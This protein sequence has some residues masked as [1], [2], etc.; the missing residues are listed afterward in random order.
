MAREHTTKFAQV[1]KNKKPREEYRMAGIR[2]SNK[3]TIRAAMMLSCAALALSGAVAVAQETDEDTGTRTL[4]K[5]TVTARR[6]EENQQEV[7]VTV[8]TFSGAVLE[9]RGLTNITQIADFTPGL[10]IDFTSPISGSTASASTFIRGVGQSDFLLTIDPG[11]G[12]YVDGVYIA[13][14]VGGVVDLLSVD[15]VEV[16]KGPQGTLF[17]R[18]TIGGAINI[19]SREPGDEFAAQGEFTIGRFDRRDLRLSADVPLT[20]TLKLALAFSSKN[21]DGYAERIPFLG[22]QQGDIL[23]TGPTTDVF[24]ATGNPFLV[25]ADVNSSELGNE[26]TD[27]GRAA[28][29]WEP[30]DRLKVRVAADY[31]RSRESGTA[32]TLLATSAPIVTDALGNADPG[33]VVPQPFGPDSLG[34]LRNTLVAALFPDDI[35]QFDDR[36][37]TGDPDTTFATGPNFS[38]L[39]LFGVNFSAQYALTE[40]IDIEVIS[41]YRELEA[42]FGRDGDNSPLNIDHTSNLYNHQQFT[43]EIKLSGANFD[44]RL[45]WTGGFFYFQEEGDDNVFVPLGGVGGLGGA[46][47]IGQLLQLDELNQVENRSI[48]LFGEATAFLTDR[49]SFTGGLRWTDEQ[50]D[51]DPIHQDFGLFFTGTPFDIHGLNAAGTATL[52][53]PLGEVSQDFSNVSFRAGTEYRATDNLFLYANVSTGFKAG[54]FTGRTVQPV[55][56]PIPFDEETLI[57]YEVGFKSDFW[58]DRARLNASAFYSDY[59]DIQIVVQEGITPITVNAAAAEIFGIEAEF[60][61]QLTDHF[62]LIGN[63]AWTEARFTEIDLTSTNALSST[64]DLDSEFANTPEWKASIAAEYEV[65]TSIGLFTLRGDWTYTS[66]IFNNAENTLS[67][68]EP[69]LHLFNAGVTYSHPDGNWDM[70]LSG[71]NLSDQRYIVSGFDQPGV[72]FT[73][74]TFSRP[75]EWALTFKYRY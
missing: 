48:A 69:D 62:F 49:W 58:N 65:P 35:T 31:T 47:G 5:V 50:K 75:R 41:A 24:A 20:D 3:R 10:T 8:N 44:D 7:P 40:S 19:T 22:E 45:R 13:R 23:L 32:S 68:V 28:L 2:K 18:N 43:Q 67:L 54:G 53:L 61:A 66:D 46:P 12:I 55:A 71:R 74:A 72:G 51:Y 70:V 52:L 16:L 21:R 64:V 59:D 42:A 14:S 26:N 27:S 37:I 36:F 25:Q 6:V 30:T 60:Q 29:H 57:Q 73:E 9:E 4:D 1:V 33:L 34:S 11:V 56:A 38:N 63:A 39:D 15:R 17:G